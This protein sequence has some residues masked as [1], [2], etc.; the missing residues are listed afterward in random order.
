MDMG[1]T[2]EERFDERVK[3]SKEKYDFEGLGV[4]ALSDELKL[5]VI[6]I[7][8]DSAD[9]TTYCACKLYQYDND[10]VSLVIS[11]LDLETYPFSFL[12]SIVQRVSD[13]SKDNI[14][15]L[16]RY[17]HYLGLFPVDG[18]EDNLKYNIEFMRI[19]HGNRIKNAIA[20]L[21]MQDYDF[22][23][24][25]SIGGTRMLSSEID[26]VPGFLHALRTLVDNRN[27]FITRTNSIEVKHGMKEVSKLAIKDFRINK[28]KLYIDSLRF[29]CQ[30]LDNN[31]NDYKI[32]QKYIRNETTSTLNIDFEEV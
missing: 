22:Y 14:D 8:G 17:T 11:M 2:L 21:Q 25:Y 10:V 3:R 9:Y 32:V 30:F 5:V 7:D 16:V 31:S 12:E 24:C 26:E 27:A 15:D 18:S 1:F 19:M 13:Y 6:K 23:Y 28:N 20:Y 29:Y 4:T